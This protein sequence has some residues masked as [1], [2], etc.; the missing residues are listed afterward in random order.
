MSLG[1]LLLWA[2]SPEAQLTGC[3]CPSRLLRAKGPP[4]PGDSLGNVCKGL[5]TEIAAAEVRSLPRGLGV[6][7]GMCR[8]RRYRSV[9]C[10]PGACALV[11]AGLLPGRW[12][13]FAN[14]SRKVA[15]PTFQSMSDHVSSCS[16]NHSKL[17][18]VF[19][20]LTWGLFHTF[21]NTDRN[22][23]NNLCDSRSLYFRV[24]L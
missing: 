7:S 16:V 18:N 12:P 9:Q 5:V 6:C 19:L 2:L 21:E 13:A 15:L 22:Q 10:T 14:R 4:T 8:P 11:G 17:A 1:E 20:G 24:F 3:H 23:R